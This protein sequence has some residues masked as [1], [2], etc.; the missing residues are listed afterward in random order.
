M[1]LQNKLPPFLQLI[2]IF[3]LIVIIISALLYLVSLDGKNSDG[4]YII[5]VKN[6][7]L[8]RRINILWKRYTG[9]S[10]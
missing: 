6:K 1:H 8:P 9:R 5:I 3:K 4:D 7:N 10:G 2:P